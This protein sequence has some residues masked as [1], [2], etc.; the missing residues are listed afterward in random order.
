MFCNACG[1]QLREGV[2]FC[3]LCGKAATA[4]PPAAPDDTVVMPP[5]QPAPHAPEIVPTPGQ[6]VAKS[7]ATAAII[8]AVVVMLGLGLLAGAGLILVRSGILG[9]KTSLTTVDEGTAK[10]DASSDS[11]DSSTGGTSD[12]P[13][14][15]D[16]TKPP[17]GDPKDITGSLIGATASSTLKGYPA[18]QLKD[19]KLDS[20]W[21]EGKA[22]Y[23]TG[24]SIEFTFG[25]DVWLSEFRVVPG[26]LKFD[27]DNGVDRWYSN[28]RVTKAKLVFA[29]GIEGPTVELNPDQQGWQTI[30]I[31]S[32]VK[33]S[34]VTFVILDAAPASTNTDHDAED[35]SISEIKIF[36]FVE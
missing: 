25:S 11:V 29:G 4:I 27:S 35:T 7:G 32:P 13:E 28:G 31:A 19:G 3:P 33:T 23:G 12:K 26:Y 8:I 30:A 14:A 24:E 5:V 20:C 36:G 9:G 1:S 16:T 21:A 10:G 15:A 22:G 18:S 17:T 6:P 2:Q 34:S